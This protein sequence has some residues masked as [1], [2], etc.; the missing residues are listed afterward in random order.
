M[1]K[2]DYIKTLKRLDKE[3]QTSYSMEHQTAHAMERMERVSAYNKA[4]I[5]DGFIVDKKHIGGYEVH[6]ID[7]KGY[8]YI[9]NKDSKKFI[10]ILSGRREQLERY[11]I[12]LGIEIT[13]QAKTAIYLATRRN[14][15]NKENEI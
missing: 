15:R 8:I 1:K 2:V 4:Y 13:N 11:Y 10:T 3:T 5:I 9:Y 7:A 12:D 6:L 14:R